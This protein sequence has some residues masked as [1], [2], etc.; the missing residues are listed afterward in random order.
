MY[1]T[2]ENRRF[3]KDY[4]IWLSDPN[5]GGTS[6]VKQSV[7]DKKQEYKDIIYRIVVERSFRLSTSYK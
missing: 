3:C 1:R 2:R 7:K 4:G 5:R 6:L